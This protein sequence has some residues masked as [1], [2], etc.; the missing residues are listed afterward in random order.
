MASNAKSQVNLTYLEC[1]GCSNIVTIPRKK[2]KARSKYHTKH[3]YCYKCKKKVAHIETKEDCFLPQWIKD[4]DIADKE[5][6]D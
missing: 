3:M 1:E 4:R 2:N 6:N 5:S